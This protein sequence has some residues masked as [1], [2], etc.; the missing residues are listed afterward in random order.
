MSTVTITK[1]RTKT[2]SDGL[3]QEQII[4]VETPQITAAKPVEVLPD[5]QTVLTLTVIVAICTYG[6]VEVLKSFTKKI[7]DLRHR[8]FYDGTI[9]LSAILIG[10][11]IG[12][13]L[14]G[15][16]GGPGSAFPIG[17]ACG[18]AAGILDVVIVKVV[19]AR[20]RNAGTSRKKNM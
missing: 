19:K 3:P 18:A 6:L 14:Y 11:F 4:S 17:V 2:I 13:C 16:V 12:F 1:T 8:N 15:S 7:R 10:A 9:R 20:I 5:L